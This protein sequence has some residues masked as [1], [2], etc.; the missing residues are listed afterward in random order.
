[1]LTLFPVEDTYVRGGAYATANYGTSSV[2]HVK[3]DASADLTRD[4][5]L[6]FD[7]GTLPTVSSA[8]FRVYAR[9]TFADNVTAVLYPVMNSWSESALTWSSRPGYV[10]SRPLGSMTL[11]S[12]T[13]AWREFDVT[14]HVRSERQAGRRLVSFALHSPAP[15]DERIDINSREA[16]SNRPELVVTP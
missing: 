4:A 5:Y 11:T 1:M 12:T 6:R 16:S 14:T 3:S 13:F 10:S 9:L 15:S 8:K 2:L 7:L